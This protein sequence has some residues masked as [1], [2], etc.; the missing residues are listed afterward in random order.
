[1]KNSAFLILLF[2][3]CL[4]TLQS[5]VGLASTQNNDPEPPPRAVNIMVDPRI[6][7][8]AVVQFLSGY[9]KRFGLI[10]RFDFPYKQDV[11]EY[12][13]KQ[14]NHPAVK[15][16]DRMS[17]EGFSFD[18][19]PAAMLYLSKP[20]ELTAER[21]FT[22]YLN[23][24]AGGA[25]ELKKF[26]EQLRDF[27]KETEFMSFFKTHHG[28]FQHMVDRAQEKLGGINYAQT[29][30][31]YYGMIQNSYNIILAPIFVG[32]FRPRIKRSDEKYDIYNILGPMNMKAEYPA[33][34]SEE[35][36]RYIAWHEF[37]HSFVNTTTEKFSRNIDRY[38]ALFEPISTRMKG[39]TYGDWQTCVNEH[40]VR[41]VTTRL[42]YQ[43]IS[44][45]AG[46]Q[47]LHGEKEHG[48]AYVEALCESLTGYEK[49]RDT[50]PTLVDY[51]PELIKV[52]ERLSANYTKQNGTWSLTTVF[53]AELKQKE[54]NKSNLNERNTQ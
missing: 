41:A 30:Q 14:K 53:D 36:F 20:P 12:F 5:E 27:A 22:E 23:K 35:S 47:A 52:F 4:S 31:D 34:G 37:S 3:L 25:E 33:F 46:E 48:F 7:L 49:H 11:R 51:Y 26:V 24:R 39:Q 29:L 9:D 43:E 13:S 44:P 28:T 38:K 19:P 42:A 54:A 40:I 17:T 15:L 16:F 10:T 45:E 2:N 21:P 8:L 18:A 50:Y 6:E 32:G 1:M